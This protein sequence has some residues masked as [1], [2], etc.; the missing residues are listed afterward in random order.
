MSNIGQA[1]GVTLGFKM[2]RPVFLGKNIQ[3][4]VL[5]LQALFLSKLYTVDWAD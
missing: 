5:A 3:T 4:S 1:F 2:L